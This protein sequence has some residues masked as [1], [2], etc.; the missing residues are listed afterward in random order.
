MPKYA[1]GIYIYHDIHIHIYL[2]TYSKDKDTV[3]ES[4]GRRGP[5]RALL[6][7]QVEVLRVVRCIP[8]W[9]L[10]DRLMS[11]FFFWWA[12]NWICFWLSFLHSPIHSRYN[13][14]L[15]ARSVTPFWGF[16]FEVHRGDARQSPRS[17]ELLWDIRVWRCYQKHKSRLLPWWVIISTTSTRCGQLGSWTAAFSSSMTSFNY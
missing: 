14:S 9:N 10:N 2:F 1:G 4:L 13:P 15:P 11:K 6:D 3:K 12:G 8:C 17:W 16:I 7:N 5:I